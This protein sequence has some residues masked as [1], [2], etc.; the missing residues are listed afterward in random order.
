MQQY[1]PLLSKSALFQNIAE[2]DIITV[3]H[4]LSFKIKSY[5]KNQF[6]WQLDDMPIN[7]GMILAGGVQIIR[8][9][10][11]GIR[12]ILSELTTGEFFGEAFPFAGIE[13]LP[14][15][16]ISTQESKILFLAMK[17]IS[18]P[19][20]EIMPIYL[21]LMLNLVGILSRKNVYLTQKNEILAE[22]TTR[23]R[24]MRYFSILA[25]QEQ[26]NILDL[27]FDRQ[28][29]A[30]YISVDRSAMSTELTR[31]RQDGLI[32]LKKNHLELLKT[33]IHP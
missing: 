32:Q 20:E 21:Q 14:V 22:R 4:F 6:V 33:S 11:A 16:V 5:H 24:L 28:E 29:L 8:D 25:A 17:N 13:R 9:D 31:M 3:L 30:D 26:N 27:P 12:T 7:M 19:S 10:A 15:G 2:T 23:Q 18:N 1:L